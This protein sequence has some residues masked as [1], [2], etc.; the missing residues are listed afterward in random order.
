[1]HWRPALQIPGGG[2]LVPLPPTV[3]YGDD[4][5]PMVVSWCMLCTVCQTDEELRRQLAEA[6]ARCCCWAN[7][8]VQFGSERSVEPL[9]D[10]L[11][12]TDP[13]V[14]R[15]TARALHQLSRDPD[16]CISMH[17]SGVVTV[18]HRYNTHWRSTHSVLLLPPEGD[19]RR[20]LI[21]GLVCRYFP[22]NYQKI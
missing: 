12:S 9:V 10:Y 5:C 2:G 3:I 1:L 7:N 18:N 13:L 17:S 4:H 14:H 21:R 15:S 16:N 22:Q 20:V 6:I 11:T 19:T 8:R